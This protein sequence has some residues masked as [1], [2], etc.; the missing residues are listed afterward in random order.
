MSE[1]RTPIVS[2]EHAPCLIIRP[3]ATSAMSADSPIAGVPQVEPATNLSLL[4][5]SVTRGVDL[6]RCSRRTEPTPAFFAPSTA[7]SAAPSCRFAS[8][9]NSGGVQVPYEAC[10]LV[11]IC[12]EKGE[13][14]SAGT[15]MAALRAFDSRFMHSG[16]PSRLGGGR[17]LS[18]PLPKMRLGKRSFLPEASATDDAEGSAEPAVG[19]LILAM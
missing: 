19:G 16:S 15:V 6:G 8:S 14:R 5:V 3:L 11:A 7:S 12:D 17:E 2:A 4:P 18:R 9:D 10:G 13:K 1:G